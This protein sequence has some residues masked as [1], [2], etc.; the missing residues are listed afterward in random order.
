M[1]AYAPAVHTAAHMRH[2]AHA[3]HARAHLA[4]VAHHASFRN[5]PVT[6]QPILPPRAPAHHSDRKAAL[7][8]TLHTLR[9]A[10]GS[11]ARFGTSLHSTLAQNLAA[12]K[13]DGALSLPDLD[14]SP[15]MSLTLAGRA[16]PRAGPC[17][18]LV[19][20]SPQRPF[21]P[22]RAGLDPSLFQRSDHPIADARVFARLAGRSCGVLLPDSP[23]QPSGR[24]HADRPEGAAAWRTMPSSRGSS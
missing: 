19:P 18:A 15:G 8:V 6:H 24:S 3:H 7:P 23:E 9:H 21:T 11:Q 10:P 4:H 14:Y 12:P 5:A 2:P 16:P 22:R 1:P 17:D 20:L 13:T